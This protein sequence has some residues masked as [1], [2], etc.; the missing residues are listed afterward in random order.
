MLTI[1]SMSEEE[2]SV[3]CDVF[4]ALYPFLVCRQV[5]A[6]GQG[7][8]ERTVSRKVVREVDDAAMPF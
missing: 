4:R 2:Y 7:I 8:N 5:Q 6:T 3:T 1:K